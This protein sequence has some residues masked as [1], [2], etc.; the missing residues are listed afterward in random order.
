MSKQDLQTNSGV[1]LS[2]IDDMLASLAGEETQPRTPQS[3]QDNADILNTVRMLEAQIADLKAQ[4]AGG[5]GSLSL[6]VDD[7]LSSPVAESNPTQVEQE[8][9]ALLDWFS[10]LSAQ[11]EQDTDAGDLSFS[12]D[13][14][15]GEQ[16]DDAVDEL[17]QVDDL[18]DV[19]DLPD[20]PANVADI[21]NDAIKA[22]EATTPTP[23]SPMD[24]SQIVANANKAEVIVTQDTGSTDLV[25]LSPNQSGAYARHTKKNQ[26]A[27]V[28][29]KFH[30]VMSQAFKKVS[31]RTTKD[32]K[33]ITTYTQRR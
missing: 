32:G 12:L 15:T 5:S 9:D 24:W 6:N 20:A 8:A 22:V 2:P 28:V 18:L 25:L 10:D 19:I 23:P 21:V 1:Q 13:D 4:I 26:P 16:L 27:P 7:L 14:L 31:E 30:K 29:Q 33:T 11:E 3:V 17:E